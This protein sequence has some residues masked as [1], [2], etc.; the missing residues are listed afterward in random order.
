[1]APQTDFSEGTPNS[2]ET[3]SSFTATTTAAEEVFAE[4]QD[5]Y[6][7][8]QSKVEDAVSDM[9]RRVRSLAAERPL[10]IVLGVA[11]I[12]FAVGVGLRLW[13]VHHE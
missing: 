7:K 4:L 6:R 9:K 8:L 13:K 2:A 12:S 11:V 1:M 10:Q 3:R 5:S